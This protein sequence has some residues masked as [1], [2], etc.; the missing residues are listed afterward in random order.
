MLSPLITGFIL[1]NKESYGVIY[2]VALITVVIMAIGVILFINK[3]N[4]VDKPYVKKPFIE[5]YRFITKNKHM[6]AII[7]INFLLQFFYVWMVIYTP[8]YLHQHMNF[9]WGQIGAIF[10]IMLSPFV[11]LGIPIGKLIDNYG[12]SKRT[13]LI[14]GVIIISTS[15]ITIAFLSP[16]SLVLWALVLFT[17]RIGAAI[18]E[19]TSEIYLFTH[20][21][22]EEAYLLS[23]YRDMAPFAYIIAP[24]V[25][26]SFL[27]IFEFKFIFI[28]LGL[29]MLTSLYYV[30]K[31]KH[32]HGV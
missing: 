18:I 13:L 12:V 26:T 24:I 25:A 20:I 28:T 23:I 7:M 17:T 16:N 1:K 14:I 22:E 29:I 21:K 31:L 10:T 9:T 2:L 19:T 27:S 4:F 30:P 11:I 6:L 15:T 32:N 3:D 8:L 5:T